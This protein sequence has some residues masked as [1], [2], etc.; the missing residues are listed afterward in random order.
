MQFAFLTGAVFLYE[1]NSLFMLAACSYAPMSVWPKR[2]TKNALFPP[3]NHVPAFSSLGVS[4]PVPFVFQPFLGCHYPDINKLC[5]V[6]GWLVCYPGDAC[7]WRTCHR[8][9]GSL[10]SRCRAQVPRFRLTA[11]AARLRHRQL[12]GMRLVCG[13]WMF[14]PKRKM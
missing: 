12:G 8:H 14:Q 10:D 3:P 2:A 1:H 9:C 5:V 7:A 11:R 13:L 4:F 6:P